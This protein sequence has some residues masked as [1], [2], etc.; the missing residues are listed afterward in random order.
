[1][2]SKYEELDKEL[3]KELDEELDEE[4]YGK[5][6]YAACY[7]KDLESLKKN[8][9]AVIN[10]G[11]QGNEDVLINEII[12]SMLATVFDSRGNYS[13]VDIFLTLFGESDSSRQEKMLNKLNSTAHPLVL[14]DDQGQ[15]VSIGGL[16]DSI[17][18]DAASIY[19]NAALEKVLPLPVAL[20]KLVEEYS[21]LDK[22]SEKP[23]VSELVAS[24]YGIPVDEDQIPFIGDID[25]ALSCNIL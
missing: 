20:I 24:A 7:S 15:K 22:G 14:P 5:K 3:D 13:Y 4:L 1:M 25:L 18:L 16:R 6:I 8:V 17:Y 19:I 9:K 21:K 11:A 10:I 12:Y 2:K 23:P